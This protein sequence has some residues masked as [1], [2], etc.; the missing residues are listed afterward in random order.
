MLPENT[1]PIRLIENASIAMTSI[2]VVAG[3]VDFAKI[4]MKLREFTGLP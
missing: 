4:S 2:P 3:L 1:C